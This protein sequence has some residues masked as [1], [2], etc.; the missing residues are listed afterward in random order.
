MFNYRNP[1]DRLCLATDLAEDEVS[2]EVA[3]DRL[4]DCR[5]DEELAVLFQQLYDKD[6]NGWVTRF[7]FDKGLD[8]MI[9][10]HN[11]CPFTSE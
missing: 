10:C 1:E 2:L 11:L 6:Q 7:D 9:C 8:D 4:V 3:S 5:Y